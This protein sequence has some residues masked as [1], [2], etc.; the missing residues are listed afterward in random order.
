MT[1]RPFSVRIT[2]ESMWPLLCPGK[3]YTLDR[4]A[5]IKEGDCVVAHTPDGIVA[6]RVSAQKSGAYM[7]ESTISWGS[8][9]CVEG[10]DIIGKIII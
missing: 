1:E 7:L 10:H 9:Y 5:A 4:E 3:T 6:K 2:G 8:H